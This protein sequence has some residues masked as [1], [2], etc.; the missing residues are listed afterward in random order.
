M[1]LAAIAGYWGSKF[2]LE[3]RT[4]RA[5]DIPISLARGAIKTG[6]FKLNVHGFYS[7]LID[8]TQGGDLACSGIGLETRRISTIGELPVY[9]YKW[10]DDQSRS[11]TRNTILGGFLGGF[12]GIPGK[13]DL[14]IEV[15]SDTGC[16][17][18]S[19]P[20]LFVIA[21]KDAFDRWYGHYTNLCWISSLVGVFGFSLIVAGAIEG[22]RTRSEIGSDRIIFR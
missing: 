11:T 1:I 17:D 21:S 6:T 16:L 2:W 19:N 20:R 4:L 14:Q 18:A 9:R 10:L 15:V 13:Y 8:R 22:L 7:I 3:S 12:E 5:M